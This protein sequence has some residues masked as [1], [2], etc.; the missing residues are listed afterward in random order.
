M[1][2]AT[3]RRKIHSRQ[4]RSYR[5]IFIVCIVIIFVILGFKYDF[6]AIKNISDKLNKQLVFSMPQKKNHFQDASLNWNLNDLFANNQEAIEAIKDVERLI[7]NFVKKYARLNFYES[8]E[9]LA[10]AVKDHEIIQGKIQKIYAFAYLS[11]SVD[12]SNTE[13][14]VLLSK[15]TKLNS[16]SE[17]DLV[18]F[19][20]FL[21]KIDKTFLDTIIANDDFF[22]K[23]QPF[24]KSMVKYRKHILSDQTESFAA[25]KSVIDAAIVRFYDEKLSSIKMKHKGNEI[26]VSEALSILNNNKNKRERLKIMKMLDKEFEKMS[27]DGFFALK[28]I[29]ES[30]RIEDK[31][32]KFENPEDARHLSNDIDP[33]IINTMIDTVT[34]NYKNISHDYYELKAKHLGRKLTY[35]DR[36]I[37]LVDIDTKYDINKSLQ[38][39]L[40]SYQKLDPKITDIVQKFINNHWIDYNTKPS[41]MGGAYCYPIANLHPYLMLNHIGTLQDLYTMAHEMGHGIHE[42][43]SGKHGPLMSHNPL[44]FAET[45]SIFAE[46][47]AFD[48]LIKNAKTKKERIAL[49][50]KR[51]EDSINTIVRQTAFF[52]FEQELHRFARTQELTK[53]DVNNIW[54]KVQKESLGNAFDLHNEYKY[55]WTYVSHFIHSPFYVYSYVFGGL[56]ANALYQEYKKDP[57]SFQYN[58]NYFLSN[59]A[60]KRPTE[61]FAKLKLNPEKQEFWQ[62]GIDYIRGLIE[63]LKKELNS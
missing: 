57:E 21:A 11:Y 8:F 24:L 61:I 38:I 60:I 63:E 62:S 27:N 22:Q 47:L 30:K 9:S 6:L 19:T 39:V 31:Y 44:I 54:I 51:I 4:K 41:K 2:H 58:Y 29:I 40:S 36:N 46:S 45:A 34:G 26:N 50:S 48:E 28:N 5:K 32:R 35:D 23:Y 10:S 25:E 53:E 3:R 55:Y 1:R 42:Y 37:P 59:S 43:H 12:T 33:K 13:N 56:F 7:Q 14:Q 18:F 17:S 49:I 16:K 15:I 52:K 20:S